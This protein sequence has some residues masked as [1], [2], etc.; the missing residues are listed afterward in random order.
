LPVILCTGYG[1]KAAGRVEHI[2]TILIKP[3]SRSV[4]S[5]AVREALDTVKPMA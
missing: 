3:I 5:I 2:Q 4:L 1:Q